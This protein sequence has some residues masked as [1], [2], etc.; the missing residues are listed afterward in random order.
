MDKR[1]KSYLNSKN[2]I[3]YM[4]RVYAGIDNMTGKRKQTTRR[5]FKTEREAKMELKRIEMQIFEEGGLKT[6]KKALKFEEV[7]STWLELYTQTVKESTLE[8]TKIFFNHHILPVFSDKFIDK[9]DI[10]F[11]QQ[12]INAWSKSNP[13]SYKR[14]KNLTSRVFKYAISLHLI[15]SDP[16]AFV[17]VPRGEMIEK[18]EKDITF[19]DKYELRSFLD[20]VKDDTFK[21]TFFYLLAFTGLRK[22]EALAL[23]WNDVD[24]NKKRLYVNKTLSRGE[25]AR[26]LVN[27]TKTKAGKRDISIDASTVDVLKKWKSYQRGNH[28]ILRLDKVQI[29]FDNEGNYYNPSST[30]SWLDNIFK[31]H[32]ELKKITCHGFRHTHASLLFEAGASLKDVQERLGH[33]DIQ[34]TSNIYTH[35]TQEK[36]DST[37]SLFSDF[38]LK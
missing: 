32:A 2:E 27:A 10:H 37:A 16:F 13:T 21:Y 22:S 20:T 29:I 26:I 24:L 7:Y 14:L 34:T 1:I 5:G 36:K 15:E 25:H 11:C 33:A 23:T 3:R 31:S 17:V 28:Q 8:R 6:Q 30:Y 12:V 9:I 35:V 19:Y 18:E 38:M 4:F